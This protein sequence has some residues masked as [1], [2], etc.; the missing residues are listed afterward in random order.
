MELKIDAHYNCSSAQTNEH[1]RLRICQASAVCEALSCVED[2]W[3]FVSREYHVS[4]LL[5]LIETRIARKIKMCTYE[6]LRLRERPKYELRNDALR[7]VSFT[8]LVSHSGQALLT[9]EIVE[10][11]L[12]W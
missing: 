1:R 12:N 10:S 2:L 5:T 11:A 9:Y 7:E 8:H 3:V 6:Y 4:S